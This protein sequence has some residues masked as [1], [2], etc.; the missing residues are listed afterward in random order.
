M[1]ASGLNLAFRHGDLRMYTDASLPA[2]LLAD[3]DRLM[4]ESQSMRRR[5]D[6]EGRGLVVTGRVEGLGDVALKQYRRGGLLSLVNDA[7]YISAFSNRLETEYR[8]LRHVRELAV[9][10]PNPLCLI[11]RGN[12]LV[13]AWLMMEELKGMQTLSSLCRSIFTTVP[14][15]GGSKE[16]FA[17]PSLAIERLAHSVCILIENKVLHVDLHPGNV[18]VSDD[19]ATQLIDFDKALIFKGRKN[20]LRDRYITRW[21]R[22]SIK[23]RLPEFLS[24]EFCAHVRKNFDGAI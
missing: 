8:M 9:P 15:R 14:R 7:T 22:A 23:H 18:L 16:D 24:E 5:G 20:E 2:F 17:L 19:G 4:L 10:A 13:S 3:L 11:L 12:Y 6:L 21:R 1:D